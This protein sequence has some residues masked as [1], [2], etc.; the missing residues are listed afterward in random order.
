MEL[1]VPDFYT[2]LTMDQCECNPLVT[3]GK[4]SWKLGRI[5]ILQKHMVSFGTNLPFKVHDSTFF[6]DWQWWHQKYQL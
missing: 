5:S 4:T 1:K 2:W 3:H 6:L